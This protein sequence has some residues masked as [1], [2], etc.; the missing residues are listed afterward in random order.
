M[1]VAPAAAMLGDEANWYTHR[2]CQGSRQ[3]PGPARAGRIPNPTLKQQPFIDWVRGRQGCF[4][5]NT[6]PGQRALESSARKLTNL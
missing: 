4:P 1:A 6:I 3:G 2:I 5:A